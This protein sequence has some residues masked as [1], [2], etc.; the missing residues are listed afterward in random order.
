MSLEDIVIC[1]LCKSYGGKMVLEDF[2]ARLTAGAVTCLMAPSGWGKTT[3]LRILMGLTEADSGTV[4]GLAGRRLSAVFQED[5]LCPYLSPAD[6]LRLTAPGLTAVG[7]RE[8]LGAMGLAQWADAPLS[9][10]SGGMRRRVAILR[11]L[12]APYDVLLL[13]EPYRGLDG[14]T[15]ALAIAETLRRREGRTVL[16]VTHDPEEAKA[17]GAAETIVC[18]QR[19]RSARDF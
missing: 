19:G 1:R 7:A 2:D 3:L 16:A 13:D 17:L 14:E 9:H 8:A 11:A 10:L 15:K 6:N 5:R 18:G 12:T 4:T